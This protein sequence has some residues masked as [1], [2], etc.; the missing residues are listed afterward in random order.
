[1]S[2]PAPYLHPAALVETGRIGGGTRVW[3]FAHIL[4]GAEIGADCNICDHVFIENDVRIGD[5]VTVKCGVQLWDGVTLEDDV[6][7][8]PNATFTNDAFPRS[9]RRPAAYARTV[10]C[11]GA[12][13]G[14]NATILPGVR[15]GPRA[16][17][18]AGSV[19]TRD[20]PAEA[21]VRG[22]PAAV[23]GFVSGRA[24]QPTR[25]AAA[26]AALEL[27]NGC[28]LHP[29]PHVRDRRG[30]LNFGELGAQLPFLP[31]RFFL[32]HQVPEREIRGEHAH[33]ELHQ[34][35]ICTHGSVH[36]RL[37]DGRRSDEVTLDQ[38][39]LGLYVPP[40]TWTTLT[41]YSPDAALL[42]LASDAYRK[43][44][45]IREWNEFLAAAAARSGDGEPVAAPEA[46][47]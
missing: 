1:M 14:A 23:A 18:G 47:R 2:R 42:V 15:I 22:V 32:V 9:K 43:E 30:S 46:R 25:A 29:L 44:D 40:L 27:V 26:P 39:G 24:P 3:A 11:R 5:R 36:V 31:R 10:V 4:P 37:S 19:V 20:V 7:V 35:L 13:I 45:Y 17:V 41:Q 33:R 21:I 28:R 8:G 34:Y 16:M 38:P 6:F 12:S